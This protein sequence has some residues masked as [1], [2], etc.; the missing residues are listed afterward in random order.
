MNLRE[1]LES[2]GMTLE[3]FARITDLPYSTVARL[4]R[5][6]KRKPRRG[7]VAMV[8]AKFPECPIVKDA[9]KRVWP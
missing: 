5:D 3:Q 6:H 1:W 9:P 4:A 2:Q 8:K 7:T